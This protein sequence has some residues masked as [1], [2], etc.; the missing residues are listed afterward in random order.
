MCRCHPSK[1]TSIKLYEVSRYSRIKV[2]GMELYFHHIDGM[3]S[4]CVDDEGH[5]CYIAA[6]ADVE[7]VEVSDSLRAIEAKLKEKNT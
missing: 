6:W 1:G 3:Y 5:P 4:Y 7:V 2:G